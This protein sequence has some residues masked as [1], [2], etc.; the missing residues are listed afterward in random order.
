MRL[1]AASLL[2]AVSLAA[3][4]ALAL[5]GAPRL[6]LSGTPPGPSA[7][8]LCRSSR[9]TAAGGHLAGALR[10]DD[11]LLGGG[12]GTRSADPVVALILGIIP[13]FGLG[14]WYAGDPNFITWTIVDAV[15]LVGAILITVAVDLG[16][17][18]WIAWIVE[19]GIQGYLANEYASGRGKATPRP[20]GVD[21]L[22]PLPE[23]QVRMAGA[24]P[25]LGFAF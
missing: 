4:P 21:S 18:V 11:A 22:A 5:D 24:A 1:F 10:M 12:D 3:A 15:F 8:L 2:A 14:H 13:G 20:R 16:A 17:L 23:P 9:S 25:L 19:H 6:A 7:T